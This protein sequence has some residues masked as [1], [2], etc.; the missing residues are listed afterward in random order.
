MATLEVMLN[1]EIA[2]APRCARE[3]DTRGSGAVQSCW[4]S[5]HS[6]PKAIGCGENYRALL[7][8]M[9]SGN[10]PPLATRRAAGSVQT[11]NGVTDRSNT[12]PHGHATG[13]GSCSRLAP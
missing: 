2:A 12:I 10:E 3:S 8:E 7:R 6:H 4:S 9:S 1:E 13:R 5:E 11:S